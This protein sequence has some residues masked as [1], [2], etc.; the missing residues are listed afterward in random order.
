MA[1]EVGSD[2]RAFALTLALRHAEIGNRNGN[3]GYGTVSGGK[4]QREYVCDGH[5]FRGDV[6]IKIA[7]QRSPI[8]APY[9]EWDTTGYNRSN[10]YI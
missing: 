9:L 5:Q 3:C 2:G 4:L 10:R 1:V 8:L 7:Q 6:M